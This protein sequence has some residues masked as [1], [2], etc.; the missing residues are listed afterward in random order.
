MMMYVLW[1]RTASPSCE[2]GQHTFPRRTA[3]R[4]VCICR[5]FLTNPDASSKEI[6]WSNRSLGLGR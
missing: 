2:P 1:T 5:P 4:T 6:D 3:S